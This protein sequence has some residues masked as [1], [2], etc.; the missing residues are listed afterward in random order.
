MTGDKDD[1]RDKR[2]REYAFHGDSPLPRRRSA[3]EPRRRLLRMQ[4]DLLR[5]PRGDFG[6][7]EL[8]RVAAVHLVDAAE[9]LEG[10]SGLAEVPEHHP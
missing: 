4:D 9:F 7:V 1:E 6:H 5:A 10:M 8:V 2:N 3:G